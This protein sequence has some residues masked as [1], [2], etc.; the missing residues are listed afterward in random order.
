MAGSY[1]RCLLNHLK[2]CQSI[3]STKWLYHFILPSGACES[4]SSS[5]LAMFHCLIL[6]ILV[7]RWRY[8]FEIW[9]F[10]SL[11]T[12]DVEYLFS[13]YLSSIYIFGEADAGGQLARSQF[14]LQGP[15]HGYSGLSH[16]VL[17]FSWMWV[18]PA[19]RESQADTLF[20]LWLSLRSHI[21]SLWLYFIYQAQN[22]CVKG[23][24]SY[25]AKDMDTVRLLIGLLMQSICQYLNNVSFKT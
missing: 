1:E 11:M 17:A 20:F 21:A 8:L 24:R 18:S 25:G 4:S 5:T 12:N 7:S 13:T 3:F 22:P 15:L 14:S 16:S 10:T 2:N 9:I 6:V 19:K 23:L